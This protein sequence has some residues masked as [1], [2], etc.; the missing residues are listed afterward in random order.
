MIIPFSFALA[1]S[2]NK[3]SMAVQVSP[4]TTAGEVVSKFQWKRQNSVK[5][6]D[7]IDSTRLKLS[8]KPKKEKRE[9]QKD[10][11]FYLCEVGGNIG[12]NF[13][14]NSKYMGEYKEYTNSP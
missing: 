13:L 1:P 7:E 8:L 12:K 14:Y 11:V 9:R 2:L 6:K 5:E 10:C 4:T 3:Q